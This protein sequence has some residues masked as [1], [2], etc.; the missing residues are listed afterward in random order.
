MLH[1][2]TTIQQINEGIGLGVIATKLIPKGTITWVQDPLDIVLSPEDYANLGLPAKT[3]VE[4][5]SYMNPDGSRIVCWD[6][7]KY[8]NHSCEPNCGSAGWNFELALRDI[9]PGE[10]LTDDYSLLNIDTPFTCIC[11]AH[12]CRKQVRPDDFEEIFE[13]NDRMFKA[14]IETSQNL[15][16]A[17]AELI[18]EDERQ[19]INNFFNGSGGIPSVR[20]NRR[21]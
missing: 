8:V 17:L 19:A 12:N 15:A 21:I 14:A 4:K 11:D 1:P 18:Q 16:Q 9:Q 2:D 13:I 6:G 5:Y 3:M 7:A 10:Q 20:I